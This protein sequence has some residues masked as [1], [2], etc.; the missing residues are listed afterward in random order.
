MING[1]LGLQN[2]VLGMVTVRSRSRVQNER[3]TVTLQYK[4]QNENNLFLGIQFAKKNLD[5]I[6]DLS[7]P[8]F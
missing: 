3:I 1:P 7:S 2:R 8:L 6:F 4:I 5:I